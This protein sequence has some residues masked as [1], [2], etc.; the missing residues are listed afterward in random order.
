MHLLHFLRLVVCFCVIHD[1]VASRFLCLI[2]SQA[3]LELNC[4]VAVILNLIAIDFDWRGALDSFYSLH[5]QS[6]QTTTQRN[7]PSFSPSSTSS[8]SVLEQYGDTHF[9]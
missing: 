5:L 3:T 1:L 4:C 2:D 6:S 7:R 8:V 9:F